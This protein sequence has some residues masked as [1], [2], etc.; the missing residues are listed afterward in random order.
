M[1]EIQHLCAGYGKREILHDVNL[2]VNSG[3]ITTLLGSNGCGKS[4]LLKSI[5]GLLPV[6]SGDVLVDGV[7]LLPQSATQRARQVAYLAQGRSV[8]EITV[9]R[10]VLHGRFPHLRYPRR[11][12]K[13]DYEV[14]Q[15]AMEEMGIA[16]LAT[17]PMANLS[18]GMR[19]KVYIAMALAQQAPVILLDEPTTY[20]DVS[21][22]IKFMDVV[23][24]LAGQGK[25]VLMVLHDIIM[26][27]KL[28]HQLAILQ[29]G[30]ITHVGTPQDMLEAG[31][32]TQLCQVDIQWLDTS[33][34][35]QYY[36]CF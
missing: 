15:Q 8:P 11:Y 28:S 30:A 13:E 16:H 10:M 32:L 35:R 12:Q 33:K 36:Y 2:T 17:Q 6:N 19:Q 5:V 4:T 27:M 22:Q 34:G 18:G 21:Q 9:E 1:I 7:S 29:D 20:L 3:E 26:A 25:A 14:A 24:K 31:V 23:E